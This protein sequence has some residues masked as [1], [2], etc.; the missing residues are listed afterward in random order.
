MKPRFHSHALVNCLVA[1]VMTAACMSTLMLSGCR[2]G[3]SAGSDN[4]GQPLT[5][6]QEKAVRDAANLMAAHG[7]ADDA[8]LTKSLLD[9]H[10]WK[11]AADHDK[12]LADSE[13]AGFTPYA[14]TLS[15]GKHP[16][17][18][19][20]AP[21]FFTEATPTG[22]AALMIH[23]LGHYKAYVATGKSDETD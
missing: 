12:Y 8:N 23:E 5:A 13:K 7:L 14:Y 17:A 22:R 3:D 21:R 1:V 9:K 10:I 4:V 6:D 19:V 11:A 20:L 15:D 16:S 18:I 2:Q